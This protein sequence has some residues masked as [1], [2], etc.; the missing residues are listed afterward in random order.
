MSTLRGLDSGSPRRHN[1]SLTECPVGLAQQLLKEFIPTMSTLCAGTEVEFCLV[2]EFPRSGANGVARW[3][4]DSQAL[5]Q[6]SLRH[7]GA[8]VFWFSVFHEACHILRHRV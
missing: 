8:D 2:P 5:I 4:S 7:K 6:I 3:L 1:G